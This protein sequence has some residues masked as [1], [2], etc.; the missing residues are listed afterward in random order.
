ME[1]QSEQEECSK[2]PEEK[3]ATVAGGAAGSSPFNVGVGGMRGE[4]RQR[5]HIDAS[6]R[7]RRAG[8]RGGGASQSGGGRSGRGRAKIHRIDA[9]GRVG[10]RGAQLELLLGLSSF[11]RRRA[12]LVRDGKCGWSL[13]LQLLLL[14]LLQLLLLPLLLLQQMRRWYWRKG[15]LLLPRLLLKLRLLL[16]LLLHHV[17]RRHGWH[18]DRLLSL[19]SSLCLRRR[20]IHQH[21]HRLESR[22]TSL[23][24]TAAGHDGEGRK[25]AGL[26]RLL[27]L[28]LLLL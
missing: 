20:R 6:A 8:R 13:L 10:R 12:H 16:L 5:M 19:R 26:H 4:R 15:H 25:H 22:P 14:L 21:H 27:L 1:S 18:D 9:N 11:A 28:L 24:A 17:W 3:H 2:N 23:P 7:V